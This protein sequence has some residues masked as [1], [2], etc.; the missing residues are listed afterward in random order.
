M[1]FAFH[2]PT[3]L[4]FDADNLSRYF[5]IQPELAVSTAFPSG[6]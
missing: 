2:N 6:E 1:N 5:K 4:V 3:L